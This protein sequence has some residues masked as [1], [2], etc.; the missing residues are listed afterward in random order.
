M[1][2]VAISSRAVDQAGAGALELGVVAEQ[3]QAEGGGLGVNAVAAPDGGGELVLARA[4]RERFQH[5]I[6]VLDQQVGG[7]RQLHGQAGVEHVGRGH[8]LVQEARVGAHDLGH[9]GQEGDDVVLHLPLDRVDALGVEGSVPAAGP[10]G[11]GGVL[12]D[13]P[14]L[15]H[16]GRR[17]GLRSRTRSC[18]WSRAT[19]GPPLRRGRNGGSCAPSTPDRAPVSSRT[20]RGSAGSTPA[21]R[22]PA[23]E[24]KSRIA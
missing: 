19:R 15:G 16:G 2:Q 14:E 13:G 6:H 17:H 11:V 12:G 20:S 21:P 3:L 7:A 9:V 1:A 23:P 18:T 8:A 22:G 5:Q 24:K 4:A 10:D